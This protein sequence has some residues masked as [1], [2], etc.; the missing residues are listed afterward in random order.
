[1]ARKKEFSL[2]FF[3]KA[4]SRGGKKGGV[5]GGKAAARSMTA[6]QRTQRAKKAAAARW[7]GH[8][9]P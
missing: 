1:M 9:K 4:G 5:A 7:K 6:E 2:E 8:K 3:R